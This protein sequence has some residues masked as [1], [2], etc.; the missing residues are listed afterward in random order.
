MKKTESF[1]FVKNSGG[2]W[3]SEKS[4]F[5]RRQAKRTRHMSRSR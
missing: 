4:T 1:H 5:H 3:E 2:E